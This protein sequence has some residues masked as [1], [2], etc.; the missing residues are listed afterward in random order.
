MTKMKKMLAGLLMAGTMF[1]GGSAMTATPAQAAEIYVN[2]VPGVHIRIGDR[3][4][5]PVVYNPGYGDRDRWE[6]QRY[7]Q[8]RREREMREHGRFE[9]GGRDERGGFRR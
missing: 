2:P 6:H 9:R 5:Y 3:P 7:E 8:E 4:T 1:L